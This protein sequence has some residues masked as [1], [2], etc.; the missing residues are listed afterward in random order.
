MY[1]YSQGMKHEVIVFLKSN[2]YI[3][4]PMSSFCSK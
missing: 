2:F 4:S 1:F 3:N